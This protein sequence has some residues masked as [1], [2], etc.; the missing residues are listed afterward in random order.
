MAAPRRKTSGFSSEPLEKPQE[1]L[2]EI[3]SEEV[4]CEEEKTEE[5]MPEEKP[6]P[7][8]ESITPVEDAGPRFVEKKQEEVVEVPETPTPV[9][10][11]VHPPKRNPRNIPRFSRYKKA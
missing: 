2:V 1:T 10:V 5:I 6:V 11:M 4:I 7:V 9:S 8:L 3:T